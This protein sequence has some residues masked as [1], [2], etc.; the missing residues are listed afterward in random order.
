[1]N[2]PRFN[3]AIKDLKNI[4]LTAAERS[5]IFSLIIN[6]QPTRRTDAP[7]ALGWTRLDRSISSPRGLQSPYMRTF[8]Y[9]VIFLLIFLLTGGG[10]AASAETTLPGDTLYSVKTNITE[11]LRTAFAGTPAAQAQVQQQFLNRRLQEAATLAKHSELDSSKE[12]QIAGLISAQTKDLTATINEVRAISPSEAD[13]L[14]VKSQ[15]GVDAYAGVI[16]IITAST[17][18]ADVV[19]GDQVIAA[20]AQSSASLAVSTSSPQAASA[21]STSTISVSATST[22]V[23]SMSTS[24]LSTSTSSAST[25]ATT[26]TTMDAFSDHLTKIQNLIADLDLHMG[27]TSPSNSSGQATSTSK[28]EHELLDHIHASLEKAHSLT[29]KAQI[30]YSD[31]DAN[32]YDT[33][34]QAEKSAEEAAI[35]WKALE[36]HIVSLPA[37]AGL[38]APAGLPSCTASCP[39][40]S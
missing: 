27:S 25:T 14:N 40:I 2:D 30:Q 32:A 5:R 16:G 7:V 4:R 15:A 36:D 18:K 29:A 11:P 6:T 1:M 23:I 12:K 9:A 28:S 19:T 21:T 35:L 22:P 38:P 3:K 31:G 33:L 26:T 39:G 20:A 13:S 34:L 10:L 24:E 37:G 8:K 17:S